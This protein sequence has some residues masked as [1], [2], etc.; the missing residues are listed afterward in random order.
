M[1]N[2]EL[3]RLRT[4]AG[5]VQAKKEDLG[6]NN[7]NDNGKTVQQIMETYVPVVESDDD[8]KAKRRAFDKADDEAGKKKVSLKK[9]PW[10]ESIEESDDEELEEAD[11]PDFAD[12]DD[13]G[14]KEETAKKAA[15]DKE[16][17]DEAFAESNTVETE[18]G[19]AKISSDGVAVDNSRYQQFFTWDELSAIF[20][21]EMG[22]DGFEKDDYS[23]GMIG[24]GEEMH[25]IP[26][27]AL[28]RIGKTE[29]SMPRTEQEQMRE[30]S[31]S[32]YKQYDDRGHYQEQ[33]EGETVDLSL[34]RYL[35][36]T[37]QKVTVAEDIKPGALAKAY[38]SF[39]GKK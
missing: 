36:A 19:Q 7:P 27:E 9:A 6:P 5:T 31:N 3:E 11:K 29:Q 28:Q 4:L 12:I 20:N 25:E 14:D 35:N 8:E 13:D 10:E 15:K 38:K 32:V 16:K 23:P 26:A 37:P 22:V 33:P 24:N 1:N 30:W 21:G 39:K 18:T 2:A 17:M 34:R